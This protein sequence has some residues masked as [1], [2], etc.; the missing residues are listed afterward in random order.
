MNE[1][2]SQSQKK[3]P[4]PITP[5]SDE[6]YTRIE[7]YDDVNFL[8]SLMFEFNLR[9]KEFG[10]LYDKY[11][12]KF[13]Q[14]LKNSKSEFR[15]A[16]FESIAIEEVEKS[17][18]PFG[19]ISE[20]V[21]QFIYH[22][23]NEFAPEYDMWSSIGV[24]VSG[25]ANATDEV[26][27]KQGYDPTLAIQ[28]DPSI[29]DDKDGL[30]YVGPIYLHPFYTSDVSAALDMCI[31]FNA[32]ENKEYA[33]KRINKIIDAFYERLDEAEDLFVY[34]KETLTKVHISKKNNPL[35]E[36]KRKHGKGFTDI[37][38]QDFADAFYVYDQIINGYKKQQIHD[39][40]SSYHYPDD[41]NYSYDD[42]GKFVLKEFSKH[43][44]TTLYEMIENLL[45]NHQFRNYFNV[46]TRSLSTI[47]INDTDSI[48]EL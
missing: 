8:N 20:D 7:Q 26:L 25:L 19:Y 45:E 47:E 10:T 18:E 9:V 44:I 38:P 3:P 16:F 35:E 32:L 42:D 40:L 30:T 31:A 5:R 13:E 41:T 27:L 4:Q 1:N 37:L 12:E 46:A 11:D 36:L 43:K 48:E 23:H 17:F 14:A 29:Q 34:E 39:I 33:K 24:L 6:K 21:L 28:L 2:L 22:Q 15:S